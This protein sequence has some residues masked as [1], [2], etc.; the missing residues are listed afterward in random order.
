MRIYVTNLRLEVT[1]DNLRKLFETHGK[2]AVAQIVKTLTTSE[3]TGLGF[4]EME[5]PDDAMVARKELDGK[6][7][8]GNPIK[9]FDRRITSNRRERTDRRVP[10]VRRDL[11]E[12]RQME[13]RQ[14][15]GE[16][17]LL[18]MFNELDKRE[19]EERR[20]SER[21]DLDERRMGE[22]RIGLERRQLGA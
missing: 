2:V 5:S 16:E 6:L 20:I 3:S 14:K 4:V 1:D 15:S 7:L 13:R 12:R 17:E 9:I 8:K 22:R 19:I 10:D 18:S 21:R 11:A